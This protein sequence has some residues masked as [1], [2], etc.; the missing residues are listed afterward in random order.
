MDGLSP[1]QKEIAIIWHD[2]I[3]HGSFDLDTEFYD[4]GGHSLKVVRLAGQLSKKFNCDISVTDLLTF[5]TIKEQETL[6]CHGR[7]EFP[8]L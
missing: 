5:P 7:L 1:V 4:A 2:L 6:I 8:V 3:G